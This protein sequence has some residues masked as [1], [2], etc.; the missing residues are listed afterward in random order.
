MMLLPLIAATLCHAQAP[1]TFDAGTEPLLLQHP[2]MN[3]TEIVFQFADELWSVPRSGGEAR[4]LTSGVG[5]ERSPYFSPDGKWIAF[6]GEYDGNQDAY[7]MPAEGGPP[8]RLTAHPGA[9]VALGWTRDGKSILFGSTMLA[10]TDL[11]RLFTVPVTGGF[12]KPLPLPS[13]SMGCYSPDGSK[14][15]Y[16]PG[17]KWETAWKRYRGG[18][19]YSIFVA[20]LADSKVKEIPK[21]NTN[22]EQPVWVGNKIY[23]MSDKRGPVGLYSYNTDTGNEKEEIKGEGF[24][25]KSVTAGPGGLVYEKLGSLW[26]YN[27]DTKQS[28]RVPVTIHGDFPGTRAEFKTLQAV[29]GASL[30][31]NGIRVAVASRGWVLTAPAKKGDIHLLDEKQG[32]HREGPAWSPDGRTVAYI[33]DVNDRQQLGLWDLST[34][35]EKTLDLGETPGFYYSPVWSPDSSMVAYR[36]NKTQ[37]WIVNVKTGVNTKVDTTIYNNPRHTETP[38]WSPDSKWITWARDLENHYNAIFVY[39]VDTAK[40]TCITDGFAD[41]D[42]P[43]F[44][45]GGKML[46]F[47]ASTN[48]GQSSSWLDL[49]SLN[50]VNPVSSVYA[51]V[52]KKDDPNPLQPESD[53][54]AA[55]PDA[56]AAAPAPAKADAPKAPAKP[57]APKFGIDLDGIESRIIAL[58]IPAAVHLGLVPATSGSFLIMS[59]PPLADALRRPGPPSVGKFS[60]ADRKYTPFYVGG[61]VID[62]S[63]DGS[64]A[65]VS[66]GPTVAI[67]STAMPVSPGEGLVDL[68]STQVK[69]DPKIEWA[70]MYHE[71]WRNE[72][73]LFYSP[74]ANGISIDEM[75][76]RYEPFVKNICSRNDL[77][78]L[79]IDMLGELCVGHE[80]P[81]GG[82]IPSAKQV[83]G[84]LL[85]A[86]YDFENNRYKIARIYDGER[87][88]PGLYAPL[89]QPGINAKAG[90]FLLAIDGKDLAESTDVYEALEG[91]A[92][93]QVKIKLGPKADGT[94][95]RE[96]TVV[97]VASEF[98]LRQRAWEEDNRRYVNKMT[99]GR[100]GYVH[101]PDTAQ[102]GWEAFNRYYYSQVGKDGIVVDERFN[103]GGLINDFMIHEMKKPLDAVFAPRYGK[104]WPTPGSA[105]YG[106]KV[107]II[108]QFAG[109]GGDMFPWLFRQD[110][111][112]PII[113]KRTWGG[114]IAAFGFQTIDGGAINSPDNAFYNPWTHTWD[115]ENW[116]VSPDIDVDLDPYLWR[117]GH[118]AQLDKAIEELNKRLADYKPLDSKHPPYPDRTK[119]G[120]R[121]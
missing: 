18:Q 117:Q 62:T 11:P 45:K 21:E 91:K 22:D 108:N 29:S 52:L 69:I 105:I 119:L 79:F 28:Q 71:V 113:G 25:I 35:K 6:T 40:K 115:V 70:R 1:F 54:E 48:I 94:G 51:V 19:T 42:S 2:T 53:E 23:Y 64:K 13:G 43:I 4:R 90:E 20:N 111:V 83:P 16:V 10:N 110:K 12:P 7:V 100:G 81:G 76:R 85:G 121:Y 95:S 73:L 68:S 109:S 101:V 93:K 112:G 27:P 82:D 17:I 89:A 38:A 41:A 120:V 96:V 55:K 86:D 9:D 87:W 114:L 30:S 97:P 77:N 74:T 104:E 107:M 99:N 33:T 5:A 34:A 103:H 14:I 65:L 80:F 66:A 15:A 44:D 8:K 37:L 106:P 75:E 67:V 46:Y 50:S 32:V 78:Y 98:G 63:A 26:T 92:G 72:R 47:Y 24:D 58:P 84:G 118:D 49:S 102:G 59:M 31:P 60:F 36:D 3:A 61:T 57:E 56:P 88:N 39:N 116:G